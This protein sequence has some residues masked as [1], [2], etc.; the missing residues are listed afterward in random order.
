MSAQARRVAW[1]MAGFGVL[2]MA[3]GPLP[4]AAQ[5]GLSLTGGFSRYAGTDFAGTPPG[6]TLGGAVHLEIEDHPAEISFGVD[7]SRYGE[8]AFVGSTRQLDYSAVLRTPVGGRPGLFAGIR[9]G[10]S[11]RSLSVVDEPA[12][13]DGMLVGPTLSLRIPSGLGP[14]VE[15]SLDALYHSYEELVMYGGR[16]YGTDQDGFRILLRIGVWVP[17]G[18]R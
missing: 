3:P 10:Y 16:E 18:D 8:H 12:R 6:P 14:L 1:F 7:Y 2:M 13:T 9:F 4:A 5:V 15:T 17:L 11:T